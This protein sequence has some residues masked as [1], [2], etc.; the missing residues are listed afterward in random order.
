MAP[1]VIIKLTR[2]Q[3]R[4]RERG[5]ERERER[6]RRIGEG[7]IREGGFEGISFSL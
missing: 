7:E 2:I 1:T 4:E 5:G 6:E 3:E